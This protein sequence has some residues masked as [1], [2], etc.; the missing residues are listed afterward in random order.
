M[1][2]SRVQTLYRDVRGRPKWRTI[3]TISWSPHLRDIHAQ[4]QG[5]SAKP[6]EHDRRF[7]PIDKRLDGSQ[8]IVEPDPGPAPMNRLKVRRLEARHDASGA[9]RRRINKRLDHRSSA[10]SRRSRSGP[11]C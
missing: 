4:L 11:G 9:W 7:D 10:A 8:Y 6:E 5:I 1:V 3:L 2:G